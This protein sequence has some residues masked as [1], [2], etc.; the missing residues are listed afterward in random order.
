MAHQT[1]YEV[2]ARHLDGRAFRVGF[3]RIRS[4][5][6]VL[7]CV[8][9]ESEKFLEQTGLDLHVHYHK[10]VNSPTCAL[11]LPDWQVEFSGRTLRDVDYCRK[12]Y[13]LEADARAIDNI[14]N[15]RKVAA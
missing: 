6:G 14:A 5:D 2:I 8:R 7:R 13:G 15:A 4:A 9:R 1:Q 12:H 11:S 3:S 10:V